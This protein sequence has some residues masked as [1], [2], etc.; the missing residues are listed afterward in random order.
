MAALGT[1]MAAG[2]LG[3]GVGRAQTAAPGYADSVQFTGLAGPAA[4]AFAPDGRVFVAEKRGTV[5]IFDSLASTTPHR[6]ADLRTNV[7][8]FWDRGLLG[9]ALPPDFPATPYVYVLYTYDAP[10]GGTAP[11]WGVANQDN[12]GCPTPPGATTDGCVVQGRL[13]RLK[14][15]AAGAWDGTE[16]VLIQDWCQQFPSHSIGALHFGPDGML[17]ASG[18][19]GAGFI[20][21]DWGQFGG[22]PGSPVPS[23]PCGD[24]PG[25]VGGDMTRPTA[26][27]GALRSQQVRTTRAR[28]G[29]GGAVIRIDPATG[30]ASGDN[31]MA[32]ASTPG[33]D[34]LVAYGLRNPFRFAI[35]PGTNDLYVGDVGWI[36]WEEV[37]RVPDALQAPVP[38]FG[39]PCYEGPGPTVGFA[40]LGLALC[41]S[42]YAA[43][44]QVTAPFF[45]YNHADVVVAGDN[46]GRGSSSI[47]GLAFQEGA[48]FPPALAGALFVADYSRRCIWALQAG[49]DGVPDPARIVPLVS[50]AAAP[51]DLA[52]GPD[53]GLYYADLLGGTVHRVRWT[54]GIGTPI[55]V[56]TATPT[57]GPAPLDV[58]LDGSGSSDP[59]PGGG[60]TFAWDLDGDGV[61]EQAGAI[62]DTSFGAP[63]TYP[64]RLRVTDPLGQ[65]ADDV[66]TVSVG[67]TPPRVI[68]VTPTA[69]LHWAVGDIVPFQASASD[70]QDGPL[71]ASA[72]AWSLV[73]HHCQRAVPTDCHG[74]LLSGFGGVDRG[75]FVAPDHEWPSYLELAVIATDSL[76][77]TDQAS[78]RLDPATTTV[79]LA[80]EPAGL[81]LGTVSESHRA[82]FDWTV[83]TGSALQVTAHTPQP[84]QGGDWQFVGWS[85]GGTATHLVQVTA[86]PFTVTA[87]YV[88]VP[89]CGDGIVGYGEQCDDGSH[90]TGCC[91]ANCRLEAPGFPCDDR[92]ACTAASSCLA[93]G[94][95]E[96]DATVCTPPDLCATATGCLPSTG[97]VFAPVNCD[98]ANECT[99]DSCDG[100]TG[101]LHA[102]RQ[103]GTA[104]FDGSGACLQGA[105]GSIPEDAPPDVP[106]E[107]AGPADTGPDEAD[108]AED[109]LPDP[110]APADEGTVDAAE[111]PG[112]DV[113]DDVGGPID[114]QDPGTNADVPGEV[115][116]DSYIADPG[117]E[118]N[119]AAIGSEE[120]PGRDVA[121][122]DIPGRGDEVAS[123]PGADAGARSAGGGCQGGAAPSRGTTGPVLFAVLGLVFLG[124]RPANRRQSPVGWRR[125]SGRLDDANIEGHSRKTRVRATIA[126][127]S[128]RGKSWTRL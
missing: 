35:R 13:S 96:G 36:D 47:S 104:C 50:D 95:I 67:N 63:G 102:P 66:V 122:G 10:P 125:A 11:T 28:I 54:Q 107:E 29:S 6:F 89:V 20:S 68:L 92:N 81:V 9:L 26:E 110:G 25:G 91:S 12:D 82:P 103:D 62:V 22:S 52:V 98:D 37:N 77:A 115:P 5:Q 18:G 109:V 53:G 105:C 116:V 99:D 15:D 57:S 7:H 14:I 3:G 41:E 120:A 42:L 55:A 33:V 79:R 2:I 83:I 65:F 123:D 58:H 49:P 117:P 56:A 121:A 119:D 27:G 21:A 112:S 38:N 30:L 39:W 19:D 71:P 118:R 34:R 24:P 32:G 40:P 17:Y 111:D 46:C 59:N 69:L 74:H 106:A 108:V 70:D 64:V 44:A 73:L 114:A 43:P 87:T 113:P 97:C 76:G 75:S 84:F 51:V 124:L 45:R 85:D 93:G 8:N 80:S 86:E 88:V 128:A 4:I 126:P 61:F 127:L 16:E 101:C 31:P 1:A 90:P 60:L 72:F 100:T 94:C 78:V 23:N 48:A